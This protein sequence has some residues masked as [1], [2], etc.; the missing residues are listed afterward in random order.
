MA[1]APQFQ[2]RG[3]ETISMTRRDGRGPDSSLI[4]VYT[5]VGAAGFSNTFFDRSSLFPPSSLDVQ[6]RKDLTGVVNFHINVFA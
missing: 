2:M 3:L 4:A 5:E 6:Q 1:L